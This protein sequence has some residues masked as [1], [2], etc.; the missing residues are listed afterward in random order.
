MQRDIRSTD[1]LTRR[2]PTGAP[3][4]QPY[5]GRDRDSLISEVDRLA[6]QSVDPR[7]E[8]AEVTLGTFLDQDRE[9]VGGQPCH[10]RPF[11]GDE[12]R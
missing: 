12:L 11:A 3:T 2:D 1:Q 8:L 7:G 6:E 9:I 5:V 4:H 10:H